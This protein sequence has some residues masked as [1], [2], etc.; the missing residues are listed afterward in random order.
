[1]CFRLYLCIRIFHLQS[2]IRAYLSA[3]SH[4]TKNKASV[5]L[6]EKQQASKMHQLII[7][8]KNTADSIVKNCTTT[9]WLSFSSSALKKNRDD[10]TETSSHQQQHFQRQMS[11]YSNRDRD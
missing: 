11:S 2:K 7:F 5:G 8:F 6:F 10:L 1:M 9:L 3:V 4:F